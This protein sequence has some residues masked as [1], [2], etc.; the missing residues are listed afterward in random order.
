M[1]TQQQILNEAV[2]LPFEEQTELIEKISRNLRKAITANNRSNGEKQSL[3]VEERMQLVESLAGSLKSDN[4]P[5]SKEE[6]REIYY[7]H[8]AEKY[9]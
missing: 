2:A 7:E 3:S 9:K 1:M 8:L 6:S 4:A 5:I